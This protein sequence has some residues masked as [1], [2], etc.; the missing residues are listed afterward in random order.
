MQEFHPDQLPVDEALVHRLLSSQFPEW[1]E[2]PI[3]RVESSGTVNAMFRLGR[4]MVVRL[5]FVE[6]GSPDIVREQLWLPRLAPHMSARIPLVLGAGVPDD[7]YPCAWSVLTWIPG[8][9]PT[10]G[11]LADPERLALDL[12]KFILALRRVDIDGAPRGYR[13]GAVRLLDEP[14]RDCIGQV[15]DLVDSGA[16]SA[17]WDE[18]LNAPDWDGAPVWVHCDLLRANVLVQDDGLAAVLDFAAAGIGDPASDLMAGW[19]IL[20]HEAR[21]VFRAALDV[22]D[23]TWLRGR[24]WAL[25]QAVIALPYYR[26]TNPVMADDSLRM[27]QA[28]V[29]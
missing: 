6:R 22:D 20:P 23:A 25:S 19:S 1:A 4:E 9:V 27:L 26:E 14:V 21:G 17:A 29:S 3:E 12:G 2:L 10:A 16:L 24:G 5:P 18:V 11:G 13:G 28:L 8:M 7:E 15:G